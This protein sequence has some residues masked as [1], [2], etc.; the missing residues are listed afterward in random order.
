MTRPKFVNPASMLITGG[1]SG[2]GKAIAMEAVQRGVNVFLIA[3]D[4]TKLDAAV[5][6]L[7]SARNRCEISAMSASVIDSDALADAV[8]LAETKHG[9]IE[10]LV[11]S[12]G[13][14]TPGYFEDLTIEDFSQ[15]IEVNFLGTVRAIQAVLP[16]MK[17][18]RQGWITN[19]SSVAG[20]KG[21]FG[22]TAY[23]GSKFAVTGFS[24]ALKAEMER[25][26]IGVSVVCPPDTRTPML[27]DEN[28]KKPDELRRLAAAGT[29]L[30]PEQVARAVWSGLRRNRFLITPGSDAKLFHRA[31]RFAPSLVDW[32]LRRKIRERSNQNTQT[33]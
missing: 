24:E 2:I 13:I 18:R 20:F 21:V 25:F 16:S 6:E 15:Q 17:A 33:D 22:Y 12:A 1:S 28:T 9:P 26:N 30:E 23:C 19:V 32:F 29:V 7:E 11:N 5:T 27:D 4:S 14:S 3:R 31:N 8:R 10:L